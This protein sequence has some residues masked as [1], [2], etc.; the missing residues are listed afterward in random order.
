MEWRHRTGGRYFFEHS[1][2]TA[3]LADFSEQRR[4]NPA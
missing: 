1:S 3:S 4:E 2:Y